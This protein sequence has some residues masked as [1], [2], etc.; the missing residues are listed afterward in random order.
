MYIYIYITISITVTSIYFWLLL[1]CRLSWVHGFF[2]SVPVRFVRM[3]EDC[4]VMISSRSDSSRFGRSTS[5]CF[6]PSM[7]WDHQIDFNR[8]DPI[9]RGMNEF[10][11]LLIPARESI[12]QFNT[13]FST[14]FNTQFNTQ[15]DAQFN[16][17][18]N[19]QFK[20]QFKSQ[21]LVGC[22]PIHKFD[23]FFQS[24]H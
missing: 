8:R 7:V 18:F 21:F 17:Q 1:S 10:L 20:S 22:F 11:P 19:T 13:Q 6:P 23:E 5:F 9:L 24:S 4:P 16:T 12:T 2:H 14:Q 3:F 15:F